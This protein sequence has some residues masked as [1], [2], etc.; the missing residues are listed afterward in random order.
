MERKKTRRQGKGG[1]GEHVA[2]ARHDS[3]QR[4]CSDLT[5]VRCA[6]L[7]LQ[8]VLRLH[9]DAPLGVPPPG[10]DRG[11]KRCTGG[12]GSQWTQVSTSSAVASRRMVAFTVCVE[13]GGGA[14]NRHRGDVSQGLVL[15]ERRLRVGFLG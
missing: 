12:S 13:A 3:R 15:R 8:D 11:G 9:P 2:P 5:G 4:A 1:L 6:G 7:P 10:H 14:A